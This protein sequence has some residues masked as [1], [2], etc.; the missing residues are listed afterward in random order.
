MP[1]AKERITRIIAGNNLSGM[2]DVCIFLKDGFKDIL[3]DL[4]E[5]EAGAIRA[6]KRTRKGT[7]TTFSLTLNP[8]SRGSILYLPYT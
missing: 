3:Q 6:M 1:A 8:R 7:R 2:V 4:M 5:A